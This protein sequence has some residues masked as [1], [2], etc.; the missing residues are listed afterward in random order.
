[1]KKFSL[2]PFLLLSSIHLI[3]II[4]NQESLRILTKPLL[5]PALF[6]FYVVQNPKPDRGVLIAL[7][8]SFLGDVFL[9][10]EGALF[11]LI[12]LG[13]FLVT[14]LLYTLK[15]G[16]RIIK[17]RGTLIWASIPFLIYAA[18]LFYWVVP[19]LKLLAPAVV[20]YAIVISSFGVMCVTYWMQKR[21][22]RFLILTGALLFIVSDSMIALNQFYFDFNFFGPWVMGT[23]L[24]AQYC[25]TSF[26][27]QEALVLNK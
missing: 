5:L 27:K 9:L 4:T 11:F 16:E 10:G 22:N 21:R 26:F 20:I 18:M 25:I 7:L 3:S 8:F 17:R 2:A 23:Y 12:G 15:M 24:L 1:M 13:N 6:L 14:Q 19:R